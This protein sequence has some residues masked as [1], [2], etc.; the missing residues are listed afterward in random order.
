MDEQG[1]LKV[2]LAEHHRD[3][4]QMTANLIAAIRVLRIVRFDLN[5]APILGQ[6]KMMGSFRMIPNCVQGSSGGVQQ[7]T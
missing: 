2:T 6:E 3:M 1:N 5:R 7:E 4:P